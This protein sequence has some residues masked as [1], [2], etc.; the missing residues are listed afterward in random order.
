MR[1]SLISLPWAIFNRPSI[2][3]GALKS[4]LCSGEKA[5]T[6][7]AFHPYLDAARCL[8]PD[9]YRIVCANGWAGEALYAA[10][11]FPER[12]DRA[13]EVF[14]RSLGKKAARNLPA[15]DV[16]ASRLD[17]QLD[18]WLSRHDFSGCGLAGFS[19]CF[20]QLAASLLA[21]ARL[22]KIRPD[23][24]IVFGGSSCAPGLAGAML[25]VFP[26]IDYIVA[27]EG[28]TPLSNLCRFLDGRAD[29]PGSGV[30][31][32]SGASSGQAAPFRTGCCEIPNVDQLPLP[33]FDDYFAE[34]RSSALNVIP[35]LPVEFSRGC[36]WNRCAFC[37]LN[38]QWGG[39]R[40]KSSERMLREVEYLGS[41]HRCLDFYFTD[42][43]LPP[44]EADR[45]FAARSRSDTDV[46]FFGEI[47]PLR[48]PASYARSRLGGL[49]SVQI[50][51]EALS[52]SLL[53]KMNKGVST[54]ANIAAMKYCTEA[55][56]RLDGNLILEFPAST[57][58]EVA[59]TLRCLDF[60]LPFQ[61]LKPA[62]FFLGH[63]SPAWTRPGE[64]K[65]RAIRPHPFNR[66]LYPEKI[67]AR[68]GMLIEYGI[69]DRRHQKR[70]WRPVRR[71]MMAWA[72]F[73]NRRKD[74][75]PPLTYREGGDF[76]II[77]QERPG[78]P[79]LHHRLRGPSRAIYLGC[80]EP[81][82]KNELLRRH[83]SVSEEQLTG[84]LDD[85][86]RKHL[87]FRNNDGFLA[88]AVRRP[89]TL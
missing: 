56:I 38:L 54:M 39:Y 16:L 27:G 34:L 44:A 87:L 62:A 32:R 2:Q 25:E 58:E 23:L 89:V 19:V 88:L 48:K 40:F 55:G 31:R 66:R 78:R 11:L 64:Y 82:T 74:P 70:L 71:K 22:K 24:P 30:F 77:R 59:E 49:E 46:H 69:G 42:N 80:S 35:G 73:H 43:C 15:F 60:V 53:K 52:D 86:E 20:S 61:P 81:V 5:Y 12:F 21:A 51:I 83:S 65:I 3:L 67:L 85:L 57:A 84:F 76:I 37:N 79:V 26:Q 4:F 72:D 8:G 18:D 29:S 47:R 45:F 41:R 68:L 28:E 9:T 7:T 13:G 17:R 14:H 10:L 6:V 33:N 1:I 75:S 36:W 63:G 50:G